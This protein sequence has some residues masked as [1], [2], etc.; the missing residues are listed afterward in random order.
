MYL[1]MGFIT[2][3]LTHLVVLMQLCL[4]ELCPSFAFSLESFEIP[5]EFSDVV[6]FHLYI[7]DMNNFSVINEEYCEYI[8]SKY[9]YKCCLKY[10]LDA[11]I[12]IHII[13]IVIIIVIF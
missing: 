6:F 13:G 4:K 5:T 7:S 2:Y 12:L 9:M 11:N 8:S 3:L 10:N 1:C